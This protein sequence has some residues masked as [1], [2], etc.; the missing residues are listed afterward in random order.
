[1]LSLDFRD[2][3]E[4][5]DDLCPR[6]QRLPKQPTEPHSPPIYLSSVYQ[7]RDPQQA[8][9]L[10]GG[11]ESG[12]V[13]ARDGHPNADLLAEKCRQLHGA[14]R[15]A[16]AGS[17]MAA[18][19]LVVLSQLEPGDHIVVSNQLYGRTSKLLTEEALRFGI[20]H[21]VVD[22]CD[23]Q[24]VR[25][26]ITPQ[27]R[28]LVVETISNPLL[29]VA[30]LAAL[31][32]LVHRGGA[33]LLADNTLAGPAICRP[34]ELG[35][36][37]VME[38]ITKSM[39][40]H[41]DVILGLLCGPAGRWQRVPGVLS[42][43]GL[44]SAPFD[45]WLALRGLGTLGVR[46]ERACANALL[47]ARRL[48]EA[49]TVQAV[50]Y[51]GLADHPD[52]ELARRQFNDRFGSIVTFTLRGGTAAATAFITAARQIGFCPSL[53]EL[54]TTLSHPEST[55]HRGLKEQARQ[56]LGITG[57][58]IRLSVGIESREAVVAAIDEGLRGV[59]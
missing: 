25:A 52:H 42:T 54:S 32:E 9:A 49:K 27:T 10:L 29:R 7:C 3:T 36:D 55:S 41:S 45:C 16:I 4:P 56:A 28:L 48:T 8:D 11:S 59:T 57:G 19:A 1:L 50:Y 35:A 22:P 30:N 24:A 46:T 58:T 47:V 21:T 2:M 14:E 5:A 13:Y 17:G 44:A 37:W 15:A 20:A 18:L 33:M 53:G 43:W 39:N 26:A 38:S 23:L 12:Y 31:A 6:P 40:G 51:P 34:R